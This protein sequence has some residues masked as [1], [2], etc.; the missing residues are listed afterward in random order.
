MKTSGRILCLVLVLIT[1]LSCAA[2]ETL[3]TCGGTELD[4]SALP[5]ATAFAPVYLSS[6]ANRI[7][8]QL[9]YGTGTKGVQAT[10]SARGR[11]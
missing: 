9:T 6:G 5:Y 1:A 11:W 4:V 8:I 3:T 10:A 2:G 7:Y